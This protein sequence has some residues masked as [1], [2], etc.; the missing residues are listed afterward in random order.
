LELLAER[1]RQVNG[2]DPQGRLMTV[3]CG[4]ALHHARIALAAAGWL[5]QVSRVPEADDPDLLARL[6]VLGPNPSTVAATR[7]AE[8]I[9]VRHTDRRPVSDIEPSSVS[10]NAIAAA[11]RAETG[12]HVCTPGQ[13]LDLAAAMCRAAAIQADEPRVSNELRYW[14]SRPITDGVGL[15]ADVLPD[16]PALTTVPG[17]DFGRTGT[18]PV[19]SGHDNAAVYAVLFGDGDEPCNWL[20]A[21]EA[22]SAAWL[23]AT[24]LGVSL[25]PLSAAIEVAHARQ[26]LRRVLAGLGHPYLVLRLGMA[27]PAT[28]RLGKTP[29]LPAARVVDTSAV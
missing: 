29:R 15:P 17:R 26:I 16:Q 20:R 1:T 25:V 19:G 18:L 11:A 7:V 4:A 28:C 8:A 6:V 10:I 21:G 2:I 22:L 5:M 24:M 27:D 3:S 14:T 13:V 23:T 9:R 12:F